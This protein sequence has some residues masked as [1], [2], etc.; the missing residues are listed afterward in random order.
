MVELVMCGGKIAAAGCLQLPTKDGD[1]R[2]EGRCLWPTTGLAN[3][4]QGVFVV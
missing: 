4:T 2:A 3:E 1:F